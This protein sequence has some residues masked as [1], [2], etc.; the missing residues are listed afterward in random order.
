MK[1]VLLTLLIP[2]VVGREQEFERLRQKLQRISGEDG[3]LGNVQL[4]SRKD[5]K[6]MTIGEK[7]EL[8]YS[9]AAGLYSWQI[10]DDDDVSEDSIKLILEAISQ[11]PDCITFQ[12]H[13]NI[14]GK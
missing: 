11:N 6:G 9:N 8:L 14:D 5:N 1:K 10:D 3:I 12:E 4:Q 13:I 7:R 2:T